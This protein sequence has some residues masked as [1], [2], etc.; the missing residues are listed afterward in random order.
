MD[1]I[2][3]GQVNLPAQMTAAE[4]EVEKITGCSDCK[5]FDRN[6]V[7]LHCKLINSGHNCIDGSE[8]VR[9]N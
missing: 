4:K 7:F 5:Y 3:S 8:F 2:A 9:L 6:N 1:N